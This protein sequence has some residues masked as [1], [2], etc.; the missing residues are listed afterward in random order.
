MT[1]SSNFTIPS[2]NITTGSYSGYAYTTFKSA[3]YTTDSNGDYNPL[4][5]INKHWTIPSKK[6]NAPTLASIAT[7]LGNIAESRNIPEPE[8]RALFNII[9]NY[10]S[11]PL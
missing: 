5:S 9:Y 11:R 8:L 4:P 1:T 10:K 3:D 6:A 7:L 2:P